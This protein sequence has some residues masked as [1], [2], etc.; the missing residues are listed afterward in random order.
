MRTTT[1]QDAPSV[2]QQGSGA[3]VV[4]RPQS[5]SLHAMAVEQGGSPLHPPFQVCLKA[6][7]Y[8]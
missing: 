3:P 6:L 4:V 7:V 8:L 1:T 5:A 2:R